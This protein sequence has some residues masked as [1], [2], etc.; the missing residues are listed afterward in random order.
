VLREVNLR[1]W[2]ILLIA[3]GLLATLCY[4]Y[5]SVFLLPPRS[6]SAALIPVIDAYMV[7]F[8]LLVAGPTSL[9][10]GAILLGISKVAMAWAFAGVLLLP[11][12]PVF[13][14]AFRRQRQIMATQNV[15]DTPREATP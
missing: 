6:Q 11:A 8:A 15:S 7:L 3:T 10:L 12:P 14:L 1:F 13:L 2:A 4:F 5:L 9:F